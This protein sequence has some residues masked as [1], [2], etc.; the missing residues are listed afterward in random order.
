MVKGDPVA[1]MIEPPSG[2]DPAGCRGRVKAQA[3]Q[4]RPAA[5]KPMNGLRFS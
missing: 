5:G 2:A 3:R 4:A 1:M